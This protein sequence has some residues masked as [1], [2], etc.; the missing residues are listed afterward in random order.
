VPAARQRVM[1]TGSEVRLIRIV[2]AT[3]KLRAQA[4]G[5]CLQPLVAPAADPSSVDS[6][7]SASET[8]ARA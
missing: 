5:H 1:H 7:V 2:V 4:P 8:F 6:R 3:G